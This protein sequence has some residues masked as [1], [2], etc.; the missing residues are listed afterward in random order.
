MLEVKDVVIWIKHIHGNAGARDDLMARDAGDLAMIS[1]EG[2]KCAIEKMADGKDGRP[3][4]GYK[5]VGKAREFWK[6]LYE[7]RRGDLVD[8]EVLA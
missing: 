6:D 8:I 2:T 1:I 5:P 7:N 4:S 3:T